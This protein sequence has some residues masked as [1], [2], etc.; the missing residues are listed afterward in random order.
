MPCH[1]QVTAV[2]GAGIN[3]VV[4]G[5]AAWLP[6]CD[7]SGSLCTHPYQVRPLRSGSH[8]QARWGVCGE[9]GMVE[10]GSRTCY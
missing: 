3:L 10:D 8:H 9:M 1:W 2:K 4:G 6:T 5:I 7:I